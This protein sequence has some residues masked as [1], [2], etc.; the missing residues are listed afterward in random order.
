VHALVAI[1]VGPARRTLTVEGIWP[2]DAFHEL[3]PGTHVVAISEAGAIATLRLDPTPADPTGLRLWTIRNPM[4]DRYLL[5]DLAL[6]VAGVGLLALLLAAP[7]RLSRLPAR[8]LATAFA[9]RRLRLGVLGLVI[10]QLLDVVT[11]IRGRGQLLYE[12]TAITRA[13]VGDWGDLGFLAV[14]VPAI[15][16]VVLLAARLPRRWAVVPVL[17]TAAAVLVVVAGNIRLLATG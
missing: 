3:H 7:P 6:C 8:R 1:L 10:V 9:D 4:P 2:T 14:K 13:M 15:L 17:A 16:A 11:S 12:G 5:L